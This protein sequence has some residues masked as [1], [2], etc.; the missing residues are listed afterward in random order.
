MGLTCII[1]EKP[2]VA[3]D[4]ARVLGAD[5]PGKGCLKGGGYVV[6]WAVGHLI[7]QLNPDE[8]DARWKYWRAD[9]LP[10]LPDEIPLKVIPEKHVREQYEH[11]K[12]IF[13]APQVD[14][15]ICATD[16]GREGE[17]I[18]RRIYKMT[19]CQKPF[20]RLWIS[21]M[22]E[23][24]IAEGFRSVKDGREYDD[25][26][27]S[28]QCRADADWLVGMNG[29]RAF[30]L[31]YDSL[32]SVGRV[33]TPTLSLLVR[34]ELEIRNFVPEDYYEVQADFG[35]YTGLWIDADNKTRIAAPE[36]AQA[37]AEAVKGREGAVEE[38]ST[39]RKRVPPPL[40]YD[41]TTL[42]REANA[43]YGFT[44]Q[45]T[46]D[47]A[48]ALYEK[49]KVLT[50]PRTD[51]RHLSQDMRPKIRKVLDTLPEP[52][53]ALVPPE[54]DRIDPGKR[55]YDDEKLT[56]HHAIVPT[57]RRAGLPPDEQ[58]LY[59]MVVR[60]L[61][62]AFYPDYVYDSMTAV[63]RVGEHRFLSR[64]KAEVAPGWHAA[65]P[66]LRSQKDKDEPA[67]PPLQKGQPVRVK[68]AKVLSKKTQP[69]K[70]YTENTLLGE[71]ENAGRF[72]QDEEL[73]RQLKERGLGTPATRAA[74]IERLIDVQYVTRRKNALIPTDK[75]I[76]LISVAP[77]QLASPET[78]GRWEKGLNDIARG[79]M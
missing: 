71:M 31:R 34:R 74:I 63:T 44:A 77:E 13:N 51:S 7:T 49:Y 76:K 47:L 15:I 3:R 45:K 67:L 79:K 56:D 14:R 22:T 75:G 32:L 66:P 24:A 53:A 17:L 54:G 61:I 19:G 38:V 6:T 1:A 62:A 29:S 78:T 55:V 21:S 16:A 69:P 40:L 39:E 72:V 58:K 48:Q 43:R 60:Q 57:G 18:F 26:Y 11:V 28:A 23:E 42:Q 68:S 41:L 20:S 37:I 36:Q 50:Y 59:E 10:I 2:S 5:S 73:R 12:T 33:Q 52:F 30:T 64:G 8:I 25:L 65:N 4:I 9:T 35:N 46:L 70:P 27:L